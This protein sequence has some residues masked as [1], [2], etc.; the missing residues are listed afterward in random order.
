MTEV[1][2]YHL[3]QSPL[4]QTLPGLLATSLSRGWRVIVQGGDDARLRFLDSHL[5]TTPDDSFLPHGLEGDGSAQ[6]IWLTTSSDNPNK[7]GVLMLV[8]GAR[9]STERMSEF[10]LVTLFFDGA[11]QAALTKAREDWATVVA[12]NIPAVYWAQENGSWVQ[13]AKSGGKT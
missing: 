8:D 11:D 10:D 9:S 5:W 3:T 12:A 13:K 2:F 7:A 6:P 1:R 4:E